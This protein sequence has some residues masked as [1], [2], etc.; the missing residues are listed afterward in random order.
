[1]GLAQS[2]EAK[3]Q[4]ET[5]FRMLDMER[6]GSMS[7]KDL[8]AVAP[9]DLKS[10]IDEVA[11][12][13]KVNLNEL[14]EA[15]M[16]KDDV[17]K[18]HLMIVSAKLRIQG[19]KPL[20]KPEEVKLA[21]TL[22]DHG[23]AHLFKSWDEN[24]AKEGK[25]KTLMVSLLNYH[26]KYPGGLTEYIKKAKVLLES[27][28]SGKNPFEGY[29]PEVP[30][31]QQLNY[32]DKNFDEFEI[33]G[34]NEL[35][36]AGFVLVAGGLGE[37]LGYGG[38]KVALP[39]EITTMTCYL[40]FYI[41][42][43]LAFQA[44]A[45][46]DVTDTK[47]KVKL[48]FAIM[49]S[50][51]THEP[52]VKLLEDN[53]YFGMPKDQI[54][55]M[56]QDKVP[57]LSNNDAAFAVKKGDPFA[58]Q[59]KPHGHGD[60]H[61][62]MHSHGLAKKWAKSGVKWISFFQDTN[63]LVFNALPACMGVS[64]ALDLEVNSLSVPRK[65][66]EAVGAICK[67]VPEKT[68]KNELTIN[69]EYNQLDALLKT[70]PV[71]GDAADTKTGLSPY[72][73]NINVLV[74]KAEPYA[75][76]LDKSNGIVPEFVNPKY[77]DKEKKIFKKPTRLECMMQ[78]YPRL[79]EAKAKIGFTSMER[80]ACFSAVKN[81]TTDAKAKASKTGFGESGCTGEGD[82]YRANRKKLAAIGVS[83]DGDGKKENILGIPCWQGARVCLSPSFAST[84]QQL[85]S[86]FPT[87]DKVKISATSTLVLDGDVTIKNLEL[88]GAL[89]VVA[90]PG[91]Q[92]VVD[93][94]KVANKG[95]GWTMVKGDDKE[96]DEMFRIRGYTL[97]VKEEAKHV[98][99]KPGKW[100]IKDGKATLE[101]S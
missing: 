86:R 63:G 7:A 39:L 44:L 24:N 55:L 100:V 35:K 87:P 97:D 52:T 67:L 21:R 96:V 95:H 82:L 28:R 36:S 8:A 31:G 16:K 49:T 69:V 91:A 78:D 93:E 90:Q 89:I 65:P 51:D 57:A 92:V 43:I 50:G 66:G 53:G 74:F 38:I 60:V 94:T 73:G 22:A 64:V 75:K 15:M 18:E 27:S 71:K 1:M 10:V 20:L 12:D 14:K 68:S 46:K 37:R 54:T 9:A 76:N 17:T 59:T 88:D 6:T 34:I 41:D 77:S 30:H 83:V 2:E 19:C 61:L 29:K 40:K 5:V 25:P 79:C 26:G 98:C 23:Q 56:Q 80:W 81:N 48:P 85:K 33:K 101:S 70:T 62:L 13:E 4:V 84:M 45:N 58:L 99:D 42:N 32:T 72:P 47:H 3:E 11:K